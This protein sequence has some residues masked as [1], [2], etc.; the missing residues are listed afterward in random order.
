MFWKTKDEH[1]KYLDLMTEFISSGLSGE[2]FLVSREENKVH[3]I[4]HQNKEEFEF[5]ITKNIEPLTDK[6]SIKAQVVINF[7]S[8]LLDEFMKGCISLAKLDEGKV[9]ELLMQMNKTASL[10]AF[11]MNQDKVFYGSRLT[12]YEG[13]TE[14]MY[15][16]VYMPLLGFSLAQMQGAINHLVDVF[17]DRTTSIESSLSSWTQKDFDLIKNWLSPHCICTSGPNGLTAEFNL[18]LQPNLHSDLKG[19]K[20]SPINHQDTALLSMEA[21]NHPA[22]GAGLLAILNMPFVFPDKDK[23]ARVC[24]ELNR[25]EMYSKITTKLH[26]PDSRHHFGAWTEGSLGHNPCYVCFLPNTL[27]PYNLGVNVS[28]WLMGRSQWANLLIQDLMSH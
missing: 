19:I 21:A 14:E 3:A 18:T 24:A 11:Y 10:G 2:G 23:L 13:D 9:P 8:Q 16:R 12:I 25:L 20:Q 27:H 5:L 1:L 6:D 26:L 22:F 15:T 28:F 17:S 7:R 4:N